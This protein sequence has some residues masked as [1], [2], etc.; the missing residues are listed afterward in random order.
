MMFRTAF[1][2]LAFAVFAAGFHAGAAEAGSVTVTEA[3]A[4][5]SV[6]A[7]G[8]AYA[9]IRNDGAATDELVGASTP[10]ADHADL[11]ITKEE[12]GIMKMR[13]V[14][15]IAI[16]ARGTV[17]LAPGGFHI[18]LMGLRKPLREGERIPLVLTFRKA[19]T[20]DVEAT[21]AKAG[22]TAAGHGAMDHMKMSPS[23]PGA[24]K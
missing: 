7:N 11:H 1:F 21:V 14:K 5:T 20:I 6:S 9:T 15:S 18:M 17:T 2:S 22:A 24:A 8:V 13:S 10:L 19:G 3:W 16:P 12:G 4:R 23:M